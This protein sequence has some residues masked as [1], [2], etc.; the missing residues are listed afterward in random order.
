V[1]G[2][3]L[4]ALCVGGAILMKLFK[5]GEEIKSWVFI[6]FVCALNAFILTRCFP[7]Q[8]YDACGQYI[9]AAQAIHIKAPS[10]CGSNGKR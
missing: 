2:Y 7:R 9:G 1:F 3:W 4:S 6:I 8:H 10:E 5:E